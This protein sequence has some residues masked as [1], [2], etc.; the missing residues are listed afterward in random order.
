MHYSSVDMETSYAFVLKKL[1]HLLIRKNKEYQNHRLI[2]QYVVVD[3]VVTFI[4]L[5]LLKPQ[6]VNEKRTCN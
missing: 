1:K 5:K 6:E 3:S 4:K 2:L